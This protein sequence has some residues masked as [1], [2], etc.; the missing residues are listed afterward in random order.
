MERVHFCMHK[1]LQGMVELHKEHVAHVVM[2]A[3]VLHAI[4][5]WLSSCPLEA[6]AIAMLQ[7]HVVLM[8]RA[9]FVQPRLCC[10]VHMG[11]NIVLEEGLAAWAHN[12]A[13]AHAMTTAHRR[14]QVVSLL[15]WRLGLASSACCP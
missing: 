15:P 5:N 11:C 10:L 1:C 6:A 12:P 13:A 8:Q 14:P 7:A 4:N 2:P 3:T 9:C